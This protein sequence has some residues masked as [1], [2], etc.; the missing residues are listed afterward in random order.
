M[1]SSSNFEDQM[2]RA[3]QKLAT[4]IIPTEENTKNAN[5]CT[6]KVNLIFLSY[7]QAYVIGTPT[8]SFW[9]VIIS[10]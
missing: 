6:D 10:L 2:N 1:H 7:V 4:D 9:A 8:I 5:V 3:F